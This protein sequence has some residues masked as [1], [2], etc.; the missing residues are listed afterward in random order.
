VSADDAQATPEP[1]ALAELERAL[2]HVFADRDLLA[3]AL[4]HSSQA[5]ED[6]DGD[7]N[8]RLEFL[9]DS[10]IGMVV[11]E[12]L[13]RAHPDWA[14]GDLTRALHALV[15]KGSLAQQARR[16]EVGPQLA[17]GRTERQSDGHSKDRILADALEALV[18]AMYLD[19]GLEPVVALAKRVFAASFVPGAPRA[20]RDA[21]T[22]LQE[23]AMKESGELPS[24]SVVQDSG[25]EGDEERF[26]V[27]VRLAGE[28][29]GSGIGRSKR[30]AEQQAAQAALSQ[31]EARDARGEVRG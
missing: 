16:L 23:T 15:D 27:D 25:V 29:L 11:A 28:A 12:L 6:G 1:A 30:K 8:E 24:Y 21:K 10:V 3:T 7:S 20:E 17:L 14:E 26:L 5:H 9:G 22:E 13:F 31:L 18:G 2:G 4:R 19:A